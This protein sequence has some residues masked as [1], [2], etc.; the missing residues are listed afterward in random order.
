MTSLLRALSLRQKLIGSFF[1]VI[2][3]TISLVATSLISIQSNQDSAV[4][5]MVQLS[6]R[7]ER[8]RRVMDN[9]Y[10]FHFHVRKIAKEDVA[11]R[12]TLIQSSEDKIKVLLDAAGALQMKRYPKE[13]GSI[14]E[15][16][17]FYVD[18]YK[19]KFLDL[20]KA[21]DEEAAHELLLGPMT[22]AFLDVCQNMTIVNGYQLRA[23]KDAMG[24]IAS[25]KVTY[26]ILAF[27]SVVIAIAILLAIWLPKVITTQLFTII[28]HAKEIASGDLTHEMFTHR[29]DGVKPLVE[30]LEQ[31]RKN[32]VENI[33]AVSKVSNEVCKIVDELAETSD[34]INDTAVDNQNRSLTVAAASDEMVSTTNDIAKNCE[35][36]SATATESNQSTNDGVNRAQ[37]VIDKLENQVTKSKEDAVL[38]QNLATQAQK[39]G[40]IVNTIDDIASQTNLLALNAAIEAARAGEAG[41]GFAVV[42]DEVRAL[43]SRTSKSTQEITRMVSQVQADADV[44][45]QAMQQSV[46]VMDGLSTETGDIEQ[47]LATLTTKV[48][49]VSDQIA[50]IATAA[51]Q[52]TVATSEIS[53]NMKGITDGSHELA[54]DISAINGDIKESRES[55]MLLM[56][57]IAKF[58]F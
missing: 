50:Q 55:A 48:N 46:S 56:D 28:K 57:M 12:A 43:A 36:A 45:D 53:S 4:D 25:D 33:Q 54:T 37:L 10:D 41:K 58:K 30:A 7:Y 14:K 11:N 49:G 1:V 6:Q 26:T 52:Q 42:A 27:A 23:T 9:M 18:S 13:I 35:Q 51:E 39:I 19:G 15:N 22:H 17:A 40:T 32:W 47:I 24:E 21:G 2:L 8:T 16:T 44:A 5:H 20:L 31:M 3:L 29:K 38:V 34:R